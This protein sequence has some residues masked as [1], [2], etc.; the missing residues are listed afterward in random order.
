[1]PM[2]TTKR[3]TLVKRRNEQAGQYL[4]GPAAAGKLSR[5]AL[6]PVCREWVPKADYSPVDHS[7]DCGGRLL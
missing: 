7:V 6:C 5:F 3:K 1:M 2:S 4:A